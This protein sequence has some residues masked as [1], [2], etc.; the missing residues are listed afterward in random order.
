MLTLHR[1]LCPVDFSDPSRR[2]L[3]H[4]LAISRWHESELTV[5]HAE[6]VLL[7]AASVQ[8][9]GDR[10]L[11]ARH[12]QELRELI[13]GAG[14]KG[15]NV[16]VHVVTGDP[17]SKILEHAAHDASNV[18]VMGTHGRSGLTRAVLGSV[19]E[20]V[21][22]QSSTPVLTIPPSAELRDDLMPFDTI[23]CAA[24]FSPACR[25]ALDIAILMGQE[26]DARLILLHAL[27]LP[28]FDPGIVPVPRPVSARTE[29][30]TFRKDALRRLKCGLPAD[31]VF[32]CRPEL[33]VAEGRP[34]DV[35]LQTAS[36]EDAKLIVMGVQ[37]R[38]ALDRLIFGS[39]TRSV[40]HAATC[41]VLSIRASPGAESEF[42]LRS[43]SAACT[44]GFRG[45][46]D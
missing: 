39:T 34:A 17:V 46:F 35:I 5:L 10:E 30:S 33:F 37:T 38:G 42:P 24:D 26:A 7:H 41:P 36:R 9:V 11:A 18:I 19:T 27:Q 16:K 25:E 2:A 3:R 29:Y 12:Y 13:D 32:R 6:D 21:V 20:R 44:Q 40:M 15:R 8:A 4:A 28:D 14:G 23:L 22:R 45:S 31:A 43:L 1:V